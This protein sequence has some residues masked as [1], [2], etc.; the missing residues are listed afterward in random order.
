MS[1][2]DQLQI[3][4]MVESGQVSVD[5]AIGMM[6]SPDSP[7]ALPKSGDPQRWLRVRVTNLETGK[8]RV[9]VN[10]PLNL[11]RWGLAVGSRFAPELA[12]LSF[13]DMMTELDQH[14]EGRIVEVEDAEDNQRV[15][16][17]IE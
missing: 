11:M 15:E 10:I 14:A 6:S 3:L 5:D 7:A 1:S 9:S 13:D 8:N 12:D 16:I 2:T 17:Y 4:Q